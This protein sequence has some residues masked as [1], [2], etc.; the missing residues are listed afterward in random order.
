[1]L[2]RA[3]RA[4][5]QSQPYLVPKTGG[6][7]P[8]AKKN[9]STSSIL[10]SSQVINHTKKRL[11]NFEWPSEYYIDEEFYSKDTYGHDSWHNSSLAGLHIHPQGYS[12]PNL[13]T[14]GLAKHS[15]GKRDKNDNVY[16]D[17]RNEE[18]GFDR[19]STADPREHDFWPDSVEDFDHTFCRRT[20]R[21]VANYITDLPYSYVRDA[22]IGSSISGEILA[23]IVSDNPVSDLFLRNL[24]LPKPKNSTTNYVQKEVD[25]M[26][27]NATQEEWNEAIQE[28]SKK[29][30][31][32]LAEFKLQQ[33]QITL[34]NAPGYRF[35]QERIVEEFGGPRPSD[36]GLVRDQFH[37][38]DPFKRMCVFAGVYDN[39]ISMESLAY[40]AARYMYRENR[41]LLFPA[42][43]V[44]KN[45][46]GTMVFGNTM[47]D[48]LGLRNEE[49]LPNLYAAHH[50]VWSPEGISKVWGGVSLETSQPSSSFYLPKGSLIEQL[51]DNTSRITRRMEGLRPN[52]IKQPR[53]IILT[54]NDP[55][56]KFVPEVSQI[57]TELA[58]LAINSGFKEVRDGQPI[59]SVG[60]TPEHYNTVG[61]PSDI[62]KTIRKMF[63]SSPST[64]VFIV[65][66]SSENVKKLISDISSGQ[67][68]SLKPVSGINGWFSHSEVDS[69]TISSIISAME[70][71]LDDAKSLE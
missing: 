28:A 37:L 62:E 68:P 58:I 39:T 31:I 25:W 17:A 27:A 30:D 29:F 23:R 42:D 24:M 8:F 45:G 5:G 16:V 38:T 65:N 43:V 20:W 7:K 61:I 41:Y 4:K 14:N 12:Y 47:D 1:M 52:V 51:T 70:Q 32:K 6:L 18:H 13:D 66:R 59:F 69:S 19:L 34:L 49:A 55:E 50:C 11:I 64:K 56:K 35:E 21:D 33:W 9:F 40:L 3:S 71:S 60:Y 36:L 15:F 10:K 48:I 22:P 44:V 26:K 46:L 67:E 53:A 2:T 54:V 63:D 57:S